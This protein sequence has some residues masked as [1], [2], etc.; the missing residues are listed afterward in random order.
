MSTIYNDIAPATHPSHCT[1]FTW[2]VVNTDPQVYQ[3]LQL[4]YMLYLFAIASFH[5]YVTNTYSWSLKIYR[6]SCNIG[7]QEYELHQLFTATS[8]LY[9][10]YAYSWSLKIYAISCN[11][12]SQEYELQQLLH[13]WQKHILSTRIYLQRPH[14]CMPHTH[15]LATCTFAGWRSLSCR[16]P[17]DVKFYIHQLFA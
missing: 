1:S 16:G 6:I 9:A 17:A 5:L 10:T 15:T 8:H 13:S 11:M 7:S 14:T 3:L 12:G 2:C 4:G